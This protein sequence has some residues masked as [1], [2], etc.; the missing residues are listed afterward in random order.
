VDE[1]AAQVRTVFAQ[2]L[3]DYDYEHI[4]C[5]NASLDDTVEKLRAIA[6]VDKRVK[7][8]VNSRNVG[9]FRNISRGL[10]YTSG[11][12]VVPM[13]PADVQDPPSVLPALVA[14]MTDDIDVVYGIRKQRGDGFLLRSARNMYYRIVG[15]AQDAPPRHAGEF[16]LARRTVIDAVIAAAGSYP[17]V[18][19]L[20]AKTRPRYDTVEYA[21]GTREVGTSRNSTADLID[22]A[23]NGIVSTVRTPMRWALLLGTLL[24]LTGVVIGLA[25]FVYFLVSDSDAEQGIATLIVATFVFGGLN[26]F[27]IG[28]I[29]EFVLSIHAQLRPE[30]P[31]TERELINL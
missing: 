19:G 6:A 27:F 9:P 28:L 2:Q 10:T 1:C 26:L 16:L 11:D 22:Q 31:V 14:K 24:A 15:G 7:V 25:N 21:W 13:I 23:F 17:Y 8:V 20:V 18:R 29:G 5:D 3:P 12:L 30:P 4:F